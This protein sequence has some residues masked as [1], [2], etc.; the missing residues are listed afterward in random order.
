MRNPRKCPHQLILVIGLCFFPIFILLPGCRKEVRV[1]VTSGDIVHANEA[2]KLGDAAFIRKDFY[3]ALVKYLESVK[4]NPRN[5]YVYNT[6]GITYSQLRYFEEAAAA[7]SRSI[8]LSPKYPYSYNNLGSILLAQN[9]L[10]KAEKYFRKAISLKGDE[11]SFHLNIGSLYLEKKKRDKALVEWHTALALD[12]N[13]LSKNVS[14]SL[15]SSAAATMERHYFTARILAYIGN[16]ESA[17]ENLQAAVT[18]GFSDIESIRKEPDF[19][20][21]RNDKRFIDFIE[22]AETMIK[23]RA[24]TGLPEERAK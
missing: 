4:L 5:A 10:K 11:A 9:K 20:P 18:D 17:I 16:V 12:P 6:L 14:V 2:S 19:N 22:N 1:T 7:F 23:L 8:K 3:A 13:I 15:V 21:I 24:K